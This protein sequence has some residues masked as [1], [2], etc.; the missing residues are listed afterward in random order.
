M[1]CDHK[2]VDSNHCL[3]CGW[4]PP[5]RAVVERGLPLVASVAATLQALDG[6]SIAGRAVPLLDS[7]ADRLTALAEFHELMR[8]ESML[9]ELEKT[10]PEGHAELVRLAATL[11]PLDA[12]AKRLADAARALR[13]DLTRKLD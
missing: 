10:D 11:A 3:K 12:E 1:P 13:A 2:F 9:R 6:G 8:D 5:A 7:I 4:R